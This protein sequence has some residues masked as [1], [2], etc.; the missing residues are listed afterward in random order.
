M[1]FAKDMLEMLTSAYDR[2]DIP[3]LSRGEKPQ[4]N[5]GKLFYLLGYGFDIIRENTERVRLWDDI[6]QAQGKSLDRYGGNYGVYR[7]EASDDIYRVMIKVK[8]LSMLSAGQL[9]TIINAAAI[10]FGVENTEVR[11]EELFP[12][13]VWLYIDEDKVDESRVK[14]ADTIA[15]LMR[16]IKAAGVGMRIFLVTYHTGTEIL[17][18]GIGAAVLPRIRAPAKYD[19]GEHAGNYK[20]CIG[21][22]TLMHVKVEYGLRR[23]D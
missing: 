20:I 2:S 3:R 14:I 18:T 10:L 23:D 21:I 13:K 15:A 8:I 16:R 4:T 5:V 9:D 11:A 17:Y 7:G 19:G 6:D 22:P 1:S 12:A